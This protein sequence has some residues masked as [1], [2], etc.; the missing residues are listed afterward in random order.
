VV[1]LAEYRDDDAREK[2][3]NN[4]HL[5]II[6]LKNILLDHQE[7]VLVEQQFFSYLYIL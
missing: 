4:N 3:N 5:R 1:A 2:Q 6:N 7:I